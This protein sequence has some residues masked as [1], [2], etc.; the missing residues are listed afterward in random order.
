MW[1]TSQG[2]EENIQDEAREKQRGETIVDNGELRVN[3]KPK[4]FG[5]KQ[6]LRHTALGI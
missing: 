2:N 4:C 5:H 6:T 1:K 3:R